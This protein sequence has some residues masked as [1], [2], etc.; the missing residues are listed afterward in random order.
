M[1]SPRVRS[2]DLS[3]PDHPSLEGL[4][5][6]LLVRHGE[7]DIPERFTLA[8]A[9]DAPLS[10]RGRKQAD[11]LGARLAGTRIHAIYSSDLAR[12]HDTARAVE[13]HHGIDVRVDPDLREVDLW[14]NAPQHKRL[15]EI[16][17]REQLAELFRTVSR[18]RRWSAYPDC[19]DLPKFRSRVRGAI[20]RIIADHEGQRVVVA[21]HSGVINAYL[22]AVLE[23]AVDYVAT[24]HHTSIS[25]V[26]GADERRAV[27]R[28]NDYAHLVSGGDTPEWAGQV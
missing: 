17:T 8:D 4:C 18:T 14:A 21:A 7:Q 16:Y 12:A 27:L 6:L 28:V 13:R 10:A 2:V 19:E 20:D 11:A 15:D 26:R 5:E 3:S 22:G 1:V 23:S 9:L 25:V 24:I